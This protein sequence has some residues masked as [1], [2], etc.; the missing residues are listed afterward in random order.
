MES[1]GNSLFSTPVRSLGPPVRIMTPQAA[2]LVQRSLFDCGA[3]IAEN[4][5]EDSAASPQRPLLQSKIPQSPFREPSAARIPIPGSTPRRRRPE[6]DDGQ[7]PVLNR[8]CGKNPPVLPAAGSMTV[9]TPICA[10]K[11]TQDL[12]NAKVWTFWLCSFQMASCS[13]GLT[14]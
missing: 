7:W 9:L 6:A 8:F 12:L 4:R 3:A 5:V 1:A 13:V 2:A 10:S 14:A 11:K